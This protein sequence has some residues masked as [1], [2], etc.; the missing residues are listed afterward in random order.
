MP[1]KVLLWR[2]DWI[3]KWKKF[4]EI[5][6]L[7][8][9]EINDN[10]QGICLVLSEKYSWPCEIRNMKLH[11]RCSTGFWIRLWLSRNFLYYTINLGFR[12]ESFRNFSNLISILLQYLEHAFSRKSIK[13]MFETC[14]NFAIKKK[15]CFY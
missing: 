1:G 2:S 7:F 6:V 5:A 13:V 14:Q 11:L 9:C 4:A 15:K 3:W 12:F 10:A 8:F